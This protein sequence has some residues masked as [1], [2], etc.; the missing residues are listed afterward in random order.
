[1]RGLPTD[2][3]WPRVGG[4]TTDSDC[5]EMSIFLVYFGSGFPTSKAPKSGAWPVKPSFT[6]GITTPASTA[7]LVALSRKFKSTAW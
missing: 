3:R 6:V 5:R 4:N 1:M 7:L 2:L